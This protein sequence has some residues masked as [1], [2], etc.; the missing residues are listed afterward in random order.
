MAQEIISKV[1]QIFGIF[2]RVVPGLLIYENGKVSYVTE[3]GVQFAVDIAELHQVK[4][5]F[6][7]M[8]M[9]FDTVVN[10]KKY[11]FAFSKPNPAAPEL[12][13][14]NAEILLRGMGVGKF[15][16]AI[17][18]LSNIKQD[19]STTRQWKELLNG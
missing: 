7:R 13:D 12:G 16:N 14:S 4:Y 17:G 15:W 6:L 9:G 19:K 3:E 10:G 5:P 11:Q 2:G 8:G 1:W 18:T